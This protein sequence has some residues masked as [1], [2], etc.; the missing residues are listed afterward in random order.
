[1]TILR[2]RTTGL[3]R[4]TAHLLADVLNHDS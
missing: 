4:S 1:V 3:Q 2:V